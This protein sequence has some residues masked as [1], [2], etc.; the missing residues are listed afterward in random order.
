MYKNL[1]KFKSRFV[2]SLLFII[3]FVIFFQIE[4]FKD[5]LLVNLVTQLLVF[6]FAACIPAY[7]TKRMSY[8]DIAWPFGLI[9]IG[10]ITLFFGEGYQPRKIIISSLYL[11]AGLRM[12]LGALVLL[13]KGY[14]DKEL[15]RYQ[16]QR[17]RW[18][19]KGFTNYSVSIQYEILLQCFANITFLSIP[20]MLISN[21]TLENF[22][23]LEITGFVLWIVFFVMEHLSDIQKQ[24]FLINAKKNNLKN[25]V[26]NVGLWNY[27][28]HPNYFSEWMI[29]NALILASFSSLL[30]T[31]EIYIF[32]GVL[33]SLLY[34]SFL[35]YQTLVFLTG[36]VPS[37]YYS[38][39]KRP[40]YKKYQKTTNMFF[41]NLF[42]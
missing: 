27:T 17:V 5:F 23:I 31:E 22:T 42:K 33:I 38:L 26:C 40:D 9:S 4:K 34:I 10:I 13:K 2:T 28:R 14:L 18:N 30:Y 36:A 29:W 37:E 20:A 12:G 32:I 24:A 3:V 8:V 6:L 25:Q 7:L 19:K 15:P 11:I 16:F 35:M 39:I 1:K 21:N 41:P